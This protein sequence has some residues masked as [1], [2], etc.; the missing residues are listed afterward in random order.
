MATTSGE[1]IATSVP[2][3]L[4][5]DA[6]ALLVAPLLVAFAILLFQHAG[7]LTGGTVGIAFLIHYLT[8]WDMGPVV[9]VVNLPF[10]VLAVRALGWRFTVRTFIAVGLLSLYTEWLPTLVTLE[11][12]N[13]LF[14]AVM[15]GFLVG[16]GLLILIRHKA[17]LGGTS[18][19]AV[20]LQQRRGWRAGYV[21]GTTDVLILGVGIFVR[22]PLSVGLAIVGA[23]A[24]NLVIAVNHR[25]GR[26]MGV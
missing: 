16:V 9:F 24:L 26:Y 2:H 10:Y 20:Y 19:V 11:S 4:F 25:T 12:L 17:S 5:E 1:Q 3:S 7:L 15:G 18:I 6:Q 23:L 13:R 8:G 14:A 22:D 21:Q